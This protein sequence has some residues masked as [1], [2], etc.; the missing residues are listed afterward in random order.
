MQYLESIHIYLSSLEKC[1]SIESDLKLIY[2]GT[3]LHVILYKFSLILFNTISNCLVTFSIQKSQFFHFE[4]N[5]TFS[6]PLVRCSLCST[7]GITDIL[8][9]KSFSQKLCISHSMQHLISK[10]PISVSR[11]KTCARRT[12]QLRAPHL[13]KVQSCICCTQLCT[14]YRAPSGFRWISSDVDHSHMQR[15]LPAITAIHLISKANW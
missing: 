15:D 14:F 4:T 1:I 11:P 9:Y 8:I 13:Q 7:N 3:I 6:R 12:R 2:L 5:Y 10:Q